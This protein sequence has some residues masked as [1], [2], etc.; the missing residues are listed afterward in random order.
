[1][2]NKSIPYLSI[3]QLMAELDCS[4]SF[5]YKKLISTGRLTPERIDK[6]IYFKVKDVE[7]LFTP[8]SIDLSK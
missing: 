3:N 8:H 1:M 6:R 4:K 5:I 2:I 7:S